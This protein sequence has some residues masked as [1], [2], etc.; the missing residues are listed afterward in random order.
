MQR[1]ILRS[2]RPANIMGV[3]V[4]ATARGQHSNGAV[5]ADSIRGSDP[6][7]QS[8]SCYVLL[9]CFGMLFPNRVGCKT[10][11]APSGQASSECG[12]DGERKG[13]A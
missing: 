3:N 4:L 7:Q 11:K 9:H 2:P 5:F 12:S 13:S 1:D 8:T 10:A 6:K